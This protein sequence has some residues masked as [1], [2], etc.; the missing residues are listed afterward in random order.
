MR[1]HRVRRANKVPKGSREK[2][3]IKVTLVIPEPQEHRANKV[4][5][6]SQGE[7]GDTGDTGAT[8]AQGE[9][10]PQ[11]EAADTTITDLHASQIAALQAENARLKA[12]TN[13]KPRRQSRFAEWNDSPACLNFE[14]LDRV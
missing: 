13:C 2:R 5:K 4:P 12:S 7:K 3:A 10:G 8:G 11:G 14:D 1:E 6:G 9:Q